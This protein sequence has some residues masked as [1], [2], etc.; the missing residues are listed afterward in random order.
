MST[1]K[2]LTTLRA[3]ALALLTH[4]YKKIIGFRGPVALT[5]SMY[6]IT[7]I[8][9]LVFGLQAHAQRQEA[10][11]PQFSAEFL[12]AVGECSITQSTVT[13]WPG[14]GRWSDPA[15]PG[16]GWE[17]TW[18][19]PEE[20]VT[21]SM[22]ARLR[23]HFYTY[24]SLGSSP[25]NPSDP[26]VG[27]PVWYYA[28]LL[29]SVSPDGMIVANGTMYKVT[30]DASGTEIQR[31]VATVSVGQNNPAVTGGIARSRASVAVNNFADPDEPGT[32]PGSKLLCLQKLGANQSN[33]AYGAGHEGTWRSGGSFQSPG[34]GGINLW[35]EPVSGQYNG[36]VLTFN[37]AGKPVWLT[38]LDPSAGGTNLT[39]AT[40]VYSLTYLRGRP[41]FFSGDPNPCPTNGTVCLTAGHVSSVQL[42]VPQAAG[43]RPGMASIT[44]SIDIPGS[45]DVN[46]DPATCTGFSST[47]VAT[48]VAPV[49]CRPSA[50]YLER[51]CRTHLAKHKI[52]R[53]S[54]F[55][56][57]RGG[58]WCHE[59]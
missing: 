13:T 30:R 23:L 24:S 18:Y 33:A 54:A 41:M 48:A 12:R 42:T 17:L 2:L 16:H 22:T 31:Q 34:F 43:E 14:S 53:Y 56:S 29:P 36:T 3:D 5:A 58:E 50:S 21:T 6:W 44:P 1:R 10:G 26:V 32:L 9:A 35:S 51:C 55:F 15:F 7:A 28:D 46:A 39:T 52:G 11:P 45:P 40:G 19:T 20:P 4:R 47:F 57:L 8:F 37:A 25:A 27:Q 49:N 59:L 38:N